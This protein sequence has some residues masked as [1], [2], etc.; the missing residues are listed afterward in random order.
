MTKGTLVS[1]IDTYYKKGQWKT[2]HRRIY[3]FW[4]GEKV[5]LTDHEFTT[6]RNSN[7]LLKVI[8][9]GF[10]YYLYILLFHISSSL[11]TRCIKRQ[12]L[13]KTGKLIPLKN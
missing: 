7:S 10:I 11:I 8:D 1:Y 3:G 12:W 13:I 5:I 6:V 9:M 2:A 4:D